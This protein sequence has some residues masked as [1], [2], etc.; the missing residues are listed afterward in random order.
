MD[1]TITEQEADQRLDRFLRKYF[2]P[3][4]KIKL[5]DI[6]SRIRKGTVKVN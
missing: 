1:I 5:A 4:P 2:K 3:Y 6:Y